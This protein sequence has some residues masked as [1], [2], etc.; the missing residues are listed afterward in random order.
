[1]SYDAAAGSFT[2]LVST[3]NRIR[4][5]E[6]AGCLD[7][8]GYLKI[9]IHKRIYMGHRLAWL[10]VHGE[11]PSH[12]VDHIDGNPSNNSISN[13][14]TAT[15]F[16]N[17]RN[18]GRFRTNTSGHK[19]VTWHKTRR[20]W[21]AKIMSGGKHHFLGSFSTPEDAAAAYAAAA[22]RMHGSFARFA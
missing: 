15:Q 17:M 9:K 6:R 3:T 21:D 16:E 14:R 8:L 1:M 20:K 10:Y 4:V 5:G 2:W 12:Q 18:C 22:A 19:G 13:L 11:W 7:A